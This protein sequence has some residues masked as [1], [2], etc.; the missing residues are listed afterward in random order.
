MTTFL[1]FVH[2]V[3]P[4]FGP[5]AAV[6]AGQPGMHTG[7]FSRLWA[8]VGVLVIVRPGSTTGA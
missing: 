7:L 5:A 2:S 3:A 4:V 6:P 1:L 8:R